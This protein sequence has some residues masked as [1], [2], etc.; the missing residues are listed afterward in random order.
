MTLAG[1]KIYQFLRYYLNTRQQY[2]RP[3]GAL[4]YKHIYLNQT[5]QKNHNNNVLSTASVRNRRLTIILIKIKK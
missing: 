5:A 1:N 4:L 3:R 2:V